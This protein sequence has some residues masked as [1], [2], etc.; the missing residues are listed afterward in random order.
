MGITDEEAKQLFGPT[1]QK[2][3]ITD[4]VAQGLID[5]NMLTP[6]Y[7]RD[8][9]GKRLLKFSETERSVLY[10]QQLKDKMEEQSTLN[11]AKM[12]V[13]DKRREAVD[14]AKEEEKVSY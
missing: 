7:S 6:L 3:V 11:A 12:R 9:D 8:E 10:A 5:A 1:T 2:V 14:A 13:R 4:D